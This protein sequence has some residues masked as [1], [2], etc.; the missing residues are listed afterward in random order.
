MAQPQNKAALS[1]PE[2][3]TPVFR[4]L[5]QRQQSPAR[6]QETRLD[7][8]PLVS[9][10][11][12]ACNEGRVIRAAIENMLQLSYPNY[13]IILIDDG[14][15]DDTYDIALS[16]VPEA[17]GRLRLFRQQNAGK[18]VALNLGLRIS[19]SPFVLCVEAG[20]QMAADALEHAVRHFRSPGVAAV[21]GV[22]EGRRIAGVG[23]WLSRLQ[24]VEYL[25]PDRLRQAAVAYFKTIPIAPG[26]AVMYR[27]KALEEVGGYRSVQENFAEDAELSNRLLAAGHDI[28]SEPGLISVTEPLVLR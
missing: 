6:R 2:V 16:M 15:V 14:S 24:G 5:R 9:I 8:S 17:G 20:S 3:S 1:D 25:M 18:A 22:A 28:V 10:I 7:I 13:E 27:R 21:A 12:P 19:Q 23:R 26:L 11:M 4:F